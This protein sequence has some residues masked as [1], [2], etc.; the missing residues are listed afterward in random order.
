[1]RGLALVPD[2]GF[3]SCSNDRCA[4]QGVQDV[5][6]Y[7]QLY[8]SEIRVWTLGGDLV[9]TLSGHTSFVYSITILPN[10]DIASSGEDRTM[11]IWRG[12]C[13][14]VPVNSSV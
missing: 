13:R 8:S 5:H 10:G 11:R 2:I 7:P 3:A 4:I 1:V 12:M 9:Y 14:F 6:A